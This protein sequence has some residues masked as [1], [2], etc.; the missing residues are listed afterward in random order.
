MIADSKNSQLKKP[1]CKEIISNWTILWSLLL[2]AMD[3]TQNAIQIQQPLC[4]TSLEIC[5]KILD[6]IGK[7]WST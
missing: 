3:D 5:F 6:F 7:L 2:P 1:M 4:F